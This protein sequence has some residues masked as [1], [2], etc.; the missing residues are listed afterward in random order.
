MFK[1]N[2]RLACPV[3]KVERDKSGVVV[4]TN[5]S[6]ES[7]DHL[8]LACH[9]DQALRLLA[10]PSN[11]ENEILGAMTFQDNDVVLHTDSSLMPKI[12][13]HGQVGMHLN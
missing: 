7:Y 13:K 9:S 11:Q 8:I 4:K 10:N 3:Q 1:G 2:I 6:Q 5:Y 12:L